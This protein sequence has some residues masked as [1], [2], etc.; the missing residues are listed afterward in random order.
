MSAFRCARRTFLG[1]FAASLAAAPFVPLPANADD[2]DYPKRIVFFVTPNGTVMDDFWPNDAFDLSASPILSPLADLSDR[3]IVMRHVD[4]AA[5]MVAPV[6]KDHWPDNNT[7]L[8]G[9]QGII[10]DDQSCDIGG[11]SI[12]QH[13]ADGLNA[14]TRFASLHLSTLAYGSGA[15]IAATGAYEPITPQNDSRAAF[16]DVFAEVM[17][18]P[19]G[20]A[21]LRARRGSVLDTVSTELHALECEVAGSHREK[22][23]RHLDA[24]EKLEGSLSGEAVENCTVPE[25]AEIDPFDAAQ[26]DQACDQQLTIMAHALA[27]DLTRVG[28]LLLYGNKI[29]HPWLGID[30]SHHGIAHGSEGVTADEATRRGWLVEIDRWYAERLRDFMTMLQ[31]VPEGDGTLLDHTAIVWLHEQSNAASHQRSDMPVVVAGNLHGAFESGRRID[32]GGVPHNAL[33]VSLAQAMGLPTTQFGDPNLG[34]GP[35]TALYG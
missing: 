6:P 11:I 23:Q 10:R 31:A 2:A 22:L 20:L 30:G 21:K 24:I 35:L 16:D 18:D 25:L 7:L 14:G 9:V 3:L 1:G 15:A 27:C 26:Y 32:A 4:N 12:D 29:G 34:S 17:L 8:T 13:I 19:F 5:S 33:L 28:T